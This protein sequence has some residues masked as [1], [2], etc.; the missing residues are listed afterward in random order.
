[1]C[2]RACVRR[3]AR[4][5]DRFV[6]LCE[7]SPLP[8]PPLPPPLLPLPLPVIVDV[9]VVGGVALFIARA[10][11][12]RGARRKIRPRRLLYLPPEGG[13]GPPPSPPPAHTPR[14]QLTRNLLH[15][16]SHRPPAAAGVNTLLI[17]PHT[18]LLPAFAR[19]SFL[20]FSPL[21]RAAGLRKTNSRD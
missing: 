19:R 5:C 2:V 3:G 13:G 9:S 4:V 6:F 20:S 10:H 8:L 15:S 18:L 17:L 21:A 1:M 14:S 11:S 7:R 12:A 16:R